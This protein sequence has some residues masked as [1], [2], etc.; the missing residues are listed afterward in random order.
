MKS[1]LTIILASFSLLSGGCVYHHGAASITSEPSG[2]QILRS[3]DGS[4]LGITPSTVYWK[5]GKDKNFMVLRL[6]KPGYRDKVI[7]FWLNLRHSSREQAL[8]D[9]Q[10]V[11]VQLEKTQE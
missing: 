3:D 10:A 7:S 1:L 6:H 2:A 8:A 11:E 9:P 4:N 5:Q